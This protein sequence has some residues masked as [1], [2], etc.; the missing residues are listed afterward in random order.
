M[1]TLQIQRF[2]IVLFAV[3]FA[4]PQTKGQALCLAVRK[5]KKRT[6]TLSAHRGGRLLDE[7]ATTVGPNRGHALN[8]LFLFDPNNLQFVKK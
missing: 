6:G 8:G 1:P 4:A 2:P 7:T 5:P 3:F